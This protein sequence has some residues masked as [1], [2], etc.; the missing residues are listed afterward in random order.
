MRYQSGLEPQEQDWVGLEDQPASLRGL[1]EEI[2]RVY[3]PA[4][5]AN[6]LAVQAGE[7]NWEAEIDG[8]RWT[9]QTFPYQAK[10]LQWTNER[11]R[12]LS[13]DERAVV[14]ALL[15]GT[16]VDTMLSLA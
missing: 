4:Q 9:Q 8:A 5:L 7:K 3:A 1:M 10:C 13:E 2:G 12:A 15:H 14:D 16:G 11:F 6:A